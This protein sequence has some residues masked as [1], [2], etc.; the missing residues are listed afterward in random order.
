M[1]VLGGQTRRDTQ[2]EDEPILK[3]RGKE[4]IIEESS[5]EDWE[6]G[7]NQPVMGAR[8]R[9]KKVSGKESRFKQMMML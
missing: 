1:C 6:M 9:G 5:G 7:R 8:S 3:E 2:R 4:V